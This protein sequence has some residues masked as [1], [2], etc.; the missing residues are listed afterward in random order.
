MPANPTT[1]P[2]H[3]LRPDRA[4]RVPERRR[5]A[6]P[7]DPRP[8]PS[9]AGRFRRLRPAQAAD[10]SLRRHHRPDAGHGAAGAAPHRGAA[11]VRQRACRGDRR[12]AEPPSRPLPRRHFPLDRVDGD[13]AR[14]GAAGDGR[15]LRSSRISARSAPQAWP[16]SRMI[17]MADD[18]L[19]R[20]GRLVAALRRH[21]TAQMRPAA[22]PRRDDRAGRPQAGSRDGRLR[23]A[24]H[25]AGGEPPRRF[26][27]VD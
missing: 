10:A 18:L 1:P 5:D 6:C 12:S 16:N 8:E 21:Y 23:P 2:P 24:A 26:L 19:G 25:H 20:G 7:F 22:R 13:P 27:T 4:R 3:H 15:G 14:R 17:G 9:R 11:G